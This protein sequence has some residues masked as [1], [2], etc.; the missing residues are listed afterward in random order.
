MTEGDLLECRTEA[1]SFSA[2]YHPMLCFLTPAG[3]IC[4]KLRDS[5]FRRL[6]SV[7][8]LSLFALL[9]GQ[10]GSFFAT[11][12]KAAE[13]TPTPAPTPGPVWGG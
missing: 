1:D 2:L 10:L 6:K 9:V 13:P 4:L 8:G 3:R 5:T 7:A 11:S 12:A